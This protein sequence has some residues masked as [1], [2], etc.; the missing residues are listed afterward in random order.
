M[1]VSVEGLKAGIVVI[2]V[3]EFDG[4]VGGAGD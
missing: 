2:D 3:P 1:V 4:E